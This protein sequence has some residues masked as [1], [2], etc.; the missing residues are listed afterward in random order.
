VGVTLTPV[1]Q[2]NG[3]LIVEYAIIFHVQAINV[4][5]IEQFSKGDILLVYCANQ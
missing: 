4:E 3:Q 1:I 2:L 5:S